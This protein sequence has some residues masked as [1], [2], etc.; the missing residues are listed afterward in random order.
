MTNGHGP[1]DDT[2]DAPGPSADAAAVGETIEASIGLARRHGRDELAERLDQLAARVRR[3]ETIVCVV[4][5]FKRARARSST[6]CSAATCVPSTTSLATAAVTVV[7]YAAEPSAVVRRRDEAPLVV[8]RIE[9]AD[10]DRWVAEVEGEA[11]STGRRGGRGR[12]AQRVP[13]APPGPR[14][15]ARCRRS[16]RGACCRH[17]GVPA[18]G[19]RARVRDRRVRG[20]VRAGAR[21]PR[22]R[23]RGPG[24]RSSSRSPRWTSTPEWRRIVAIDEGHLRGMDVTGRPVRAE[25]RPPRR[26]PR[27]RGTRPSRPRAG[28]RRSPRRSSRTRSV[29][30]ARRRCR[31]PSAAPAGARAAARTAG[32][33]GGPPSSTPGTADRLARGLGDVRDRLAGLAEADASWSVRLEDEFAA[34][35]TRTEF[36]FQARMRQLLRK[37]QDE[38]EQID[39]A[40]RL[41]GGR[42]ARPA[43]HGGGRQGGLPPGDGRR[44]RRPRRTS[45]TCCATRRPATTGQP[46]RGARLDAFVAGLWQSGPAFEGRAR[47]N[48]M[49]SLGIVGG[50]T[51]GVE[52]LGML[53]TLLGAA[54]VG[55]AVLGVA[56]VFGGKQVLDERRL[57]AGRSPPAGTL[58]PDR[59]RGGGPVRGGQPPG[60]AARR[61]PAP[62]A[63]P[64]RRPDPRAAPDLRRQRR[65]A[66]AGD[67]AGRGRTAAP[68]LP[69]SPPRRQQIDDLR[70]RARRLEAGHP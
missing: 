50:A 52:M 61:R 12:P 59:V 31:W 28:S 68:G 19:R 32:R 62:D 64:I 49:A 3:T 54:V 39:P 33:R 30:P 45:Q 51:V 34:L 55:P 16:Q 40:P 47:S 18:V 9:A 69:R 6:H 2:S 35:R 57:Q 7:R 60:I 70:G 10:I 23:S 41:A 11:R 25:L 4:G 63:C 26:R 67:R 65:R 8:E 56:A 21:L 44:D 1:P 24:R 13:G 37:A 5:E 29:A 38:V 15:H 46:R 14:R 20:A 43:G 36:A 48:L 53:G 17:A 58:V 42:W 27:S 22:Q 66:R